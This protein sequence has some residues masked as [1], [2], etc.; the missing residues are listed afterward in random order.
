MSFFPVPENSTAKFLF[1][2][3]ATYFD[4][5][6]VPLRAHALLPRAKLVTILVSPIKRAYS[7]YQVCVLDVFLKIMSNFL[8]ATFILKNNIRAF[9]SPGALIVIF[10]V[11]TLVSFFFD[12]ESK[13]LVIFGTI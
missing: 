11:T 13:I 8:E 3:S 2:K 5:E 12:N 4:G 9:S 10:L 6:L 1:E 7:W